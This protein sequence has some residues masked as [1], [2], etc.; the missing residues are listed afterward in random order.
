MGQR[1]RFGNVRPHFT[2][3]PSESR[4]SPKQALTTLETER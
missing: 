3:L 1:H 4:K 2:S